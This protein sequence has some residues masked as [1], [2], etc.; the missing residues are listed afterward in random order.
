MDEVLASAGENEERLVLDAL[1]QMTD[2]EASR[3]LARHAVFSP[4][5]AVREAAAK[6]LSE[7]EF[8]T[9]MPELLASLY[10]PVVSRVTAMTLPNG[11]IGYRHEFTREGQD[12]HQLLVL[13]TEYQR[14]SRAGGSRGDS[15]AR[16]VANAADS[17]L[18]RETAL[19]MQNLATQALNDRIMWVLS[20][21][22]Q[23]SLAADPA[24][25]WDWWNQRNEVFVPSEKSVATIH[26]T[27]TVSIVDQVPTGGGVST[28]SGGGSGA[29]DCLAAGTQ[30]WTLEGARAIE[31][32]RVGDLVL[33]QH[34]ETGELA[35]KPILK[36]TIRPKGKLL[37]ITIDGEQ[38]QTSGG[39]LFWVSGEGWV[40]SRNLQP[41]M[42]LHT[43][44]G[45]ARVQAIEEGDI[46]ET[47]NMVVADFNTYF[48]GNERTL[49]HDNTVRQATRAIVPGLTAE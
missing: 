48:V 15:T 5:L 22:T 33:A 16:A 21:I 42:V 41:G 44:S 38:L 43:A 47:Y 8:D 39:H 17:A 29:L 36:T 11:R 20:Q 10:S 35:Y 27:Q 30:V 24:A 31:S 18:R 19:Q 2:P 25:W 3:S 13:D 40:K 12:Q 7:R 26:E 6:M 4:S 45:L 1:R 32:L 23:Q 34:P 46:A 9:F 37:R 14:V 49:S 28:S